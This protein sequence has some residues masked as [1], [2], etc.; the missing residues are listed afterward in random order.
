MGKKDKVEK[1]KEKKYPS[2]VEERLKKIG[3]FGQG[4]DTE[5]WKENEKKIEAYQKYGIIR[6]RDKLPIKVA[7]RMASKGQ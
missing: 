3:S 5:F 4:E 2:H 6:R 1:K 7:N